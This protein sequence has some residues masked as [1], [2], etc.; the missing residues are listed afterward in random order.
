MRLWWKAWRKRLG[1]ALWREVKPVAICFTKSTW[2]EGSYGEPFREQ[3]KPQRLASKTA[4]WRV[5][6]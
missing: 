3:I 4:F 6:I 1:A 5:W 2:E